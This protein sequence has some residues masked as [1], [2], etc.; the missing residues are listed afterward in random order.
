MAYKNIDL[1]RY[2]IEQF[3]KDELRGKLKDLFSGKKPPL[4]TEVH[5]LAEKMKIEPDKVEEMIY[6]MLYTY[7]SRVGRHRKVPDSEFDKQQ[8]EM[9]I[10]VELEHTDCKELAKEIAKDHLKEMPDYYTRLKK[11]EK[12]EDGET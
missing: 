10:K 5:A 7:V 8:L 6:K 1:A 11:M 2:L 4:D 3:D 12:G 9:G